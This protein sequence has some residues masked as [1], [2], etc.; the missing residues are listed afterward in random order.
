MNSNKNPN[1]SNIRKYLLGAVAGISLAAASLVPSNANAQRPILKENTRE[2]RENVLNNA[3]ENSPD[4]IQIQ[5]RDT[6]TNTNV[7][8]NGAVELADTINANLIKSDTLAKQDTLTSQTFLADS[9]P[10]PKYNEFLNKLSENITSVNEFRDSLE[11]KLNYKIFSPSEFL[12]ASTAQKDSARIAFL[13]DPSIIQDLKVLEM[14]NN[15]DLAQLEHVLFDEGTTYNAS[16]RTIAHARNNDGKILERVSNS[17]LDLN[18][19][20]FVNVAQV[21]RSYNRF[22]NERAL[23]QDYLT[24]FP[25]LLSALKANNEEAKQVIALYTGFDPNKINVR[26]FDDDDFA[27]PGG[28]SFKTFTHADNISSKY[29]TRR[30]DA[31][32]NVFPHILFLPGTTARVQGDLFIENMQGY[33]LTGAREIVDFKEYL[34]N[35]PRVDPSLV[36]SIQIA[37]GDLED[38]KEKSDSLH[39]SSEEENSALKDFLLKAESGIGM[40]GFAREGENFN[41][42]YALSIGRGVG[43]NNNTLSLIGIYHPGEVSSNISDVQ[44]NPV[45]T[46]VPNFPGV[47]GAS[48]DS[49]FNESTTA[50]RGASAMLFYEPLAKA[51]PNLSIGAGATFMRNSKTEVEE[52][53]NNTWFEGPDGVPFNRNSWRESSVEKS[54]SEDISLVL[55]AKYTIGSFS[56][57]GSYNPSRKEVGF[58]ATL[59]ILQNKYSKNNNANSNNA[60][61]TYNGNDVQGGN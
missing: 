39:K 19:E 50:S 29:I 44:V 45:F 38:S 58:G 3:Q 32:G 7:V 48:V 1:K 8:N 28:A 25:A 17:E 22:N 16:N 52:L 18:D 57:F 20:I 27:V 30:R 40:F 60:S 13:R 5:E 21:G 33:D 59:N 11:N 42:G 47:Y 24:N 31:E 14:Y 56:I 35:M 34:Q 54:N 55:G 49:L 61:N 46:A 9:I 23:N 53:V 36:D 12:A 6:I 37:I 4:T 10:I 43:R 2:Y 26:K 15:K 41:L 51:I